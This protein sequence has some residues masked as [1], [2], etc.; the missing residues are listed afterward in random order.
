M[1]TALSD[2]IPTGVMVGTIIGGIALIILS[3]ALGYWA[4]VTTSR[5]NREGKTF[6]FWHDY[7][8]WFLWPLAFMALVIG[9]ALTF[10]I[11]MVE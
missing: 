5:K 2:S 10:A 6:S 3:L 8:H 7:A 1:F 9:I 4:Y 11:L